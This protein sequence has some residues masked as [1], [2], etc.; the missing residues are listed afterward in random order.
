[1][2]AS[3]FL[4]LLVNSAIFA[5]DDPRPGS[6][7]VAQDGGLVSGGL[8][9]YTY[10]ADTQ[11]RS[12]CT[13]TCDD[14]RWRPF[15]AGPTDVRVGS[16]VPQ[17]RRDGRI[18]WMYQG[19]FVFQ[20]PQADRGKAVVGDRGKFVWHPIRYV[21]PT[22]Q[23]P[24][25][26]QVKMVQRNGGFYFTTAEGM[27]LYLL[28]GTARNPKC[29]ADCMDDWQPLL[30]PAVAIAVAHWT[31]DLRPDSIRQ[32]SWKGRPVYRYSGDGKPEDRNGIGAGR[33]ADVLS[34]TVKD[35]AQDAL[36]SA[37]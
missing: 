12:E 11:Q 8:E 6:V 22:P 18:Q 4:A 30:A 20:N 35:Q 24:S 23:V 14:P 15:V 16:W 13:D 37:R 19:A 9:L 21:G 25:P 3:I 27:A 1:M 28:D 34:V 33:K 26:P 17:R 32:W 29:D 5:S 36:S 2:T 7:E 31:P 10:A